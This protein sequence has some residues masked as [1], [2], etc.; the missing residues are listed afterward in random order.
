MTFEVT[1]E[2]QEEI[3]TFLGEVKQLVHD[4]GLVLVSEQPL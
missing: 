1:S 4:S 2:R 3:A